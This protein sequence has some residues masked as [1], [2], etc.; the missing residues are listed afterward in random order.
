MKTTHE[1]KKEQS[2]A[3]ETFLGI[4]LGSTRIK[5]VLIGGDYEPLAAGGY[6]WENRLVDGVWTYGLDAVWAG[7][8]GAFAALTGDVAGRYGAAPSS[9]KA[10]LSSIKG[11]GVS[12]MMHGYLAFDKDGQLLV[13]FRTWR[14]T[15]TGEAA[16]ALTRAFSFN[17]PQR[18]SIA[19]LYQ[20]VLNEEPHVKD[21]AFLTTLAGYVH[22]QLTGRAVL[23][24]GD[25][26]GMFPI[27]GETGTWDERM[28]AGFDALLAGKPYPWKLP[29]ILP[30]VLTAGTNAG[31]LTPEGAR[32][33][34]PTGNLQAGIP[35]CP[36]EGDAGTGMVATNSVAERTG[37]VSAG[38]S[39]FAMVVLEKPLSRV[40]TE[41]DL[42]TTPTGKPVAM[43]HCNNCTSDLD[44]WVR[45]FDE[46][47]KLS[48]AKMDKSALYDALYFKAEEGDPD[49]GG[50]L[51]YNYYGGEP[52]T[53]LE[54]GRPLFVRKPDSRFTLAN[55][56]RA[57][58]FSA[59]GTLKLGMAI[60]TEEER[61]RI[62]RLLGHGGLFKTKGVGQR[63]MAA[64]LNTQVA[65]MESAGEGGAWG[66]ALLAAFM[67]QKRDGETLEAYLADRVFAGNAGLCAEP[68]P[69]DVQG[70]AA[71]MR[72]YTKG[73]AIE[74]AAVEHF[75]PSGN[76][77][78]SCAVI[79][80]R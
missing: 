39:I 45:L 27:D 29:A 17:I 54:E 34:D 50:L 37:N 5:A 78:E 80:G 67:R 46:V 1:Q 20:A 36:P 53:G 24:V 16:A 60:L 66:I 22:R 13:P 15:T 63:L 33:L 19:H 14:N 35:L 75:A 11:I 48:G 73:L 25:A 26:S 49:S 58:L 9:I 12:A 69:R 59:M 42:V 10:A 68:D 21:I 4:E 55:F 43:A 70:F 76:G 6:D 38:T 3:G 28:L 65:V 32:L 56:V 74:R 23:G 44:A 64:A 30:T 57:L 51:A 31:S 41:I 40:W 18:W 52:V 2:L 62:D 72:H 47:I 7:V 8:R 71:F 61:V 79:T 77:D